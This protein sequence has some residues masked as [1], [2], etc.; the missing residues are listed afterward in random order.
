MGKH[1]IEFDEKC[2]SCSGTGLYVGMAERDGFAVV[3]NTCDG[4]GK[5]HVIFQY[6]DFEG[7]ERN[8][9]IKKVL[10]CNPGISCGVGNGCNLESFGGMN[11]EDWFNGKDFPKGSEMRKYTC[12]AWWYQ[13]ADYEKKPDWKE[14]MGCNMFSACKYFNTKEKCWERWDKENK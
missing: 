6:E 11:Y 5:H 8:N 9:N 3:C 14:C 4:T 13:S 12:P 1:K 10:K 2:K 7:K